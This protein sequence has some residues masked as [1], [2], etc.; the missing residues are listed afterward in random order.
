MKLAALFSGG[1]D[2][3]YAIFLAKKA[4]HKIECLITMRPAADDSLLFHYPNS[5]MTEYLAEAMQIPLVSVPA[6]GRSREEEARALEEAVSKAKALYDIEGVVHGGIASNFQKQAFEGVC[7]KQGLEPL[8]PLWGVD[9]KKYM[10]SLLGNNFAVLIVGVSAMGLEKE[11]LGRIVDKESLAQL[12]ALSKKHA[13]NLAFEGGEAETLV[14]DCPL[15]FK[16]LHVKNARADWDG[17][18]GIFEIL[19][20]ELVSKD[21]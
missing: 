20:V 1:K 9:E 17:Q 6:P 11:W 15:Y 3:T 12:A 10:E 13:F 14:T 16:K 7:K 18:R 19:E 4:G 2:S 21:V 5:S 8:A